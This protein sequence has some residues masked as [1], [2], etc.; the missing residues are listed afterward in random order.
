MVIVVVSVLVKEVR[1]VFIWCL[2]VCFF[3]Y[4]FECYVGYGMV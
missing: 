2:L 3:G 1:D 4:G